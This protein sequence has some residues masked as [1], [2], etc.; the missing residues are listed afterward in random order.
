[1]S[2]A[3][4]NWTF[5]VVYPGDDVLFYEDFYVDGMRGTPGF[6]QRA[7]LETV[8]ILVVTDHGTELRESVSHKDDPRLPGNR[9]RRQWGCFELGPRSKRIRDLE[10]KVEAQDR[11]IRE[12]LQKR[13]PGRPRKDE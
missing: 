13:G 7:G 11:L 3:T 1:M 4:E 9:N 6:V 8:A 5:P 10:A 2:T 12:L